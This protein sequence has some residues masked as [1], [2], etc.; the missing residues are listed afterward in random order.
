MTSIELK[1]ALLTGKPMERQLVALLH[2]EFAA[3][4]AGMTYR[5]SYKR[6]ENLAQREINMYRQFKVD[7]VAVN[8]LSL[9][10]VNTQLIKTLEE[11][12]SLSQELYQFDND[13]KQQLNY[14]AIELIY[15]EIGQEANILY[16]ISG[17]LTLARYLL[18]IEMI[19]KGMRK[20]PDL[21]HALLRFTTD[22]IIEMVKRFSSL[23]YLNFMIYDPVAS[24]SLISPKQYREF[25][26]PYTQEIVKEMQKTSALNFLHVCGDTTKNLTTLAET[27]IEVLSLDQK[28]D[29]ALAKEIVGDQVTLMG[30]IDPVSSLLF[31]NTQQIQTEV[32]QLLKDVA[33]SPKRLI[34][35]SGC[36]VP[37]N[38]PQEHITAMVETVWKKEI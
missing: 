15:E 1:E 18:P 27:G 6:A 24:G 34:I 38:V 28:V 20:K 16:G 32:K 33:D 12:S 11:V 7:F 4:A 21:V 17:P 5:E 8:Y 26:L 25:C 3:Q 35:G 10:V 9:R 2:A 36:G 19:L 14:K 22:I 13:P 31:G 37:A 23:P 30:N 29:L